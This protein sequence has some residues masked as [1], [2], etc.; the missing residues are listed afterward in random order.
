MRQVFRVGSCSFSNVLGWLNACTV[1]PAER[2]S[3]ASAPRTDSSSSTIKTVRAFIFGAISSPPRRRLVRRFR[4]QVRFFTRVVGNAVRR[5]P[6][7]NHCLRKESP[8][9]LHLGEGAATAARPLPRRIHGE[10]ALFSSFSPFVKLGVLNQNT[11]GLQ[12]V[13]LLLAIAQIL[14]QD[15]PIVLA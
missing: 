10:A 5:I 2:I 12:I 9:Q 14:G 15:S 4:V 3:R 7:E 8:E 1:N 11:S 13:E 6:F